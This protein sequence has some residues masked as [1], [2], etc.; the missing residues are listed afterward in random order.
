MIL[1]RPGI[2]IKT[3]PMG[4]PFEG[5]KAAVLDNEWNRYPV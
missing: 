4:K 1:N 2:P 3:G 5:I